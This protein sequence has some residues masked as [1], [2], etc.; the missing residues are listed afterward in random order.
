[1]RIHNNNAGFYAIYER[2]TIGNP[3]RISRY[4]NTA[5]PENVYAMQ[6]KTHK[7]ASSASRDREEGFGKLYK[8]YGEVFFRY[9]WHRVGR[10]KDI[11]EDLVQETFFRTFRA[12]KKFGVQG[13]ACFGYLKKTA[14]NLLVNFYRTQHRTVSLEERIE[15]PGTDDPSAEFI[16]DKKL[17]L[18]EL[19]HAIGILTSNEKEVVRLRY[20]EEL[21]IKEIAV[22]TKKSDNAVKLTLSHAR[23]KLASHMTDAA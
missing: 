20:R 16:M 7:I 22:R 17:R 1:M 13:A 8:K 15:E 4:T 23:K 5:G 3:P 14:H 9:F 6:K 21:P 10:S 12:V 11:A 18:E 2:E 19:K